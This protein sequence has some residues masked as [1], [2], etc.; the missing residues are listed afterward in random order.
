MNNVTLVGRMV[1]DSELRYAAGTGN[2]VCRFTMA[3][4]RTF[5]PDETDFIQCVAFGKTGEV[6]AENFP[7]GRMIAVVGSIRTSSYDGQDGKKKYSTDVAVTTFDFVDSMKVDE[8]PNI[9]SNDEPVPVDD[10]DQ[11]F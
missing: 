8:V 6:I 2:A 3:V 10:G 9:N 7:K 5:K 11:P 4:K 1:R